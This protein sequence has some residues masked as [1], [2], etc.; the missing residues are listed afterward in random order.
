MNNLEDKSIYEIHLELVR[1]LAN[2]T[3]CGNLK[4]SLFESVISPFGDVR[5]LYTSSKSDNSFI[6][7]LYYKPEDSSCILVMNHLY[8]I[9][10]VKGCVSKLHKIIEKNYSSDSYMNGILFN[11]IREIGEIAE[12]F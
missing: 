12:K 10:D 5:D 3:K 2:A 9:Y 8:V 4:W 1:G 6:F 7:S 11:A